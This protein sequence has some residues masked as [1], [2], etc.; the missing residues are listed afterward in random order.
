MPKPDL[1]EA[2]AKAKATN[3][4]PRAVL[5]AE[6]SPREPHLSVELRCGGI[7]F[8]QRREVVQSCSDARVKRCADVA[9]KCAL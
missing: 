7:R 5:E 9:V 4:C 8:T 2:K 3:Y 6:E 1:F